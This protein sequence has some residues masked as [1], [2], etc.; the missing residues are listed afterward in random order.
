LVDQTLLAACAASR[1]HRALGRALLNERAM[2]KPVTP[3]TRH[4]AQRLGVAE[5]PSLQVQP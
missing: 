2:A 4:W 3:L 1:S 5:R